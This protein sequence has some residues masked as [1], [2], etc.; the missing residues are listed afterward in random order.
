MNFAVPDIKA[1]W[2]EQQQRYLNLVWE[3]KILWGSWRTDRALIDKN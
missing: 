2:W 3:R 1:K